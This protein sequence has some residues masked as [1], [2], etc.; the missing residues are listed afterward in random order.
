MQELNIKNS[1]NLQKNLKSLLLAF[2]NIYKK[3]IIKVWFQ[4]KEVFVE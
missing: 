3:W 1:E 4:I 2:G